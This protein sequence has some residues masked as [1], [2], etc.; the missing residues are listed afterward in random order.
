MII[1][2]IIWKEQFVEKLE[3]KH[4]VAIDEVEE[5]LDSKPFTEKSVKAR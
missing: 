4:G 2:K 1:N 5:V 3:T